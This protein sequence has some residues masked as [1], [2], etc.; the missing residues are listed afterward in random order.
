MEL[1]ATYKAGSEVNS[2]TPTSCSCST[3]GSCTLSAAW[4]PAQVGKLQLALR[5]AFLQRRGTAI[6]EDKA[7]RAVERLVCLSHAQQQA[8][9]NLNHPRL[10][11]V[12]PISAVPHVLL[13][14][15]KQLLCSLPCPTYQFSG[16]S[17]FPAATIA[18]KL[19]ECKALTCK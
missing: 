13:T 6:A 10:I 12:C 9:L 11:F 7:G 5:G 19:R 3:H 17:L 14:H 2:I 15:H 4:G 8:D 1:S 18:I 16:S